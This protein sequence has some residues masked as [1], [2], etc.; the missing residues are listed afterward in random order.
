[1][2]ADEPKFDWDSSNTEHVRQHGVVPPEV[3]SVLQNDPFDLGFEE[4]DG[5]RRW[6]VLGHTSGLRVLTVAFTMRNQVYRPITAYDVSRQVRAK[7]WRMK[8]RR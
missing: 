2:W 6:M 3:E 4:I 5:E 1:L 7:Y 8:G